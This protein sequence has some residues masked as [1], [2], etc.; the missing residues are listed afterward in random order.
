MRL[1][2]AF[3]RIAEGLDRS[4][5]GVIVH[6]KLRAVDKDHAR[7]EVQATGVCQLEVWGVEDRLK[8]LEKEVNREV[9][10]KVQTKTAT[11]AA[12]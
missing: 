7:L 8:V 6:A 9:K 4:H 5:N 3:L 11:S 2:S 1:L 12:T 10:L